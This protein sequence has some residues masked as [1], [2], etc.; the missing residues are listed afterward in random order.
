MKARFFLLPGAL[1]TEILRR[2][3]ACAA[4]LVLSTIILIACGDLWLCLPFA[5]FTVVF[6][7][8]S[9]LLLKRCLSGQYV[10]LIGVC[11]TVERTRLRR[12]VKLLT[13]S[14]PPHIVKCLPGGK[15]CGI[16]AGDTVTLYIAS[17]APV[18]YRGGYLFVS[19]CIAIDFAKGCSYG[20]A[21]TSGTM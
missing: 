4:C 8:I 2:V 20:Y 9:L 3:A 5:A 16:D 12:R 21:G 11:L 14:S 19:S 6:A 7:A 10:A 13:I 17:S 1:Q 15:V 18:Y